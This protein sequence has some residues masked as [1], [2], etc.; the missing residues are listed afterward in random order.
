[1]RQDPIMKRAISFTI[2]IAI[3]ILS[4]CGG[5]PIAAEPTQ[6]ALP[7]TATT[8]VEL[9]RITSVMADREEV[10]RY[11]PIELTVALDADYSNP[12]DAREVLLE[13]IF[14]APDG[15]EM[16]IPG[17]WDGDGAWKLRFTPSQE[18]LWTYSISVTDGR[19]ISAAHLGE[20]QVTPSDLHGWIQPGHLFDPG[21][22]GRYFVHHDGTPFYGVGHADALNILIDGFDIEDG[23][24]LFDTMK[25]ANENYVV[26]W[27]LYTN[28]P[29]NSSY[30]NYSVGNMRVIDSVVEDAEKEGIYLVFTI[31]DHPQ[32]RDDRHPT[33]DTGNWSRNGFN[34]LTSLEEFFVS[35]EAWAWQE[36]LYRYIIARWGYSRA[37]AMWQTVSEI[38]GTNALEQ[39]DP[40]HERVNLYFVENDPYRHPTTASGS[41]EVDWPQ[42]HAVMDVPQVHLYDF[43]EDAIGAAEIIAEWTSRMWER[44]EKPNWIGEFGVT[45]N[46]HYPE[47]FH[48]SIWAALASGAAFTPAEWNSGGA[49]GR[50]TPEMNA[51][52]ARLA[53][54]VRDLPLAQWNPSRL[55]IRSSDVEVRGWGLAGDAGGLVWVQDFSLQG[56]PIEEVRSSMPVRSGVD[57]ALEG[58]SP[59]SYTVQPYDTWH[60]MVLEELLLECAEREVCVLHL[61]D[62]TS[63]MAFKIVRN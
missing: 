8:T 39:T 55:T 38:N 20:F 7:P 6:T 2:S 46:T 12:Y 53:Q 24:G 18:G 28:S 30:D 27:P 51:D 33:W 16:T 36:N 60:D 43:G 15:S 48:H 41:G 25:E 62:F 45:G 3:F 58:L 42:G 23:V 32:L 14:T 11:E 63:D 22:S 59:G 54:F 1:M 47:L 44:G 13:G 5:T 21:Y 52:I 50:M 17:F 19:G 34:K 56:Q 40:W 35:E 26:W 10:P 31:W 4:A 9:P 49:W 61:P 57:V 29:V 37:I